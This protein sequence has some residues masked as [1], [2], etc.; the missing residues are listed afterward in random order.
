MNVCHCCE[1]FVQNKPVFHSSIK[2]KKKTNNNM[3]QL[4]RKTWWSLFR[5]FTW[6]I[7]CEY[8]ILIGWS[9]CQCWVIGRHEP[10][11]T[12]LQYTINNTITTILLTPLNFFAARHVYTHGGWYYHRWHTVNIDA[13]AYV[14]RLLSLQ[15]HGMFDFYH[16]LWLMLKVGK[17]FL[18]L[19][20]CVWITPRQ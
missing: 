15:E 9:C 17:E 8:D 14:H 18:S 10:F 19:W 5:F 20:K 2:K 13:K 3:L 1:G 6:N 16:V 4:V 7:N 12:L 11:I